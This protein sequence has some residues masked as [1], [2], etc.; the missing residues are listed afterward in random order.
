MDVKR[1]GVTRRIDDLGRI[2]ITK[3]FRRKMKIEE[4]DPLEL[5]ECNYEGQTGV[6]FVP[7]RP[8]Q[9]NFPRQRILKS[10]YNALPNKDVI[11]ALIDSG[12]N[13]LGPSAGHETQAELVRKEGYS[14]FRKIQVREKPE[15]LD[16]ENGNKIFAAPLINE[17]MNM[18]VAIL[19]VCGASASVSDNELYITS[20]AEILNALI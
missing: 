2:V 5:C 6:L 1:T 18:V 20:Q 3:E 12:N 15:H 10:M 7:Y 11:I 19:L 9:Y 17:Q 13:Y 8:L 4:G 14:F 16:L